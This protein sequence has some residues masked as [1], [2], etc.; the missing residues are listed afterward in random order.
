MSKSLQKTETK[1]KNE[2]ENKTKQKTRDQGKEG[3]LDKWN[4]VYEVI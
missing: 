1:T 3:I 4:K 2:D